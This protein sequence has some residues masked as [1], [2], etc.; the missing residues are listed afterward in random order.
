[1]RTLAIVAL[2]GAIAV[3]VAFAGTSFASGASSN[4]KANLSAAQAKQVVVNPA[5]DGK[6]TATLTGKTL[7][8]K[9]NFAHLTGPATAAQIHSAAKAGALVSLCAPCTNGQTGTATVSPSVLREFRAR[10]LLYVDV[11]TAKNPTRE[12]RGQLGQ[13]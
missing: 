3:L 5:A 11:H 1:M 10:D 4:F 9:L 6:F 8:W 12:I 2:A 13:A 7:R